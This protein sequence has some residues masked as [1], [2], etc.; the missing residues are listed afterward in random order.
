MYLLDLRLKNESNKFE[1]VVYSDRTASS[2]ILEYCHYSLKS[3]TAYVS[4]IYM[5]WTACQKLRTV[6]QAQFKANKKWPN[7]RPSHCRSI[8]MPILMKT[9]FE[10]SPNDSKLKYRSHISPNLMPVPAMIHFKASSI[11]DPFFGQSRWW[12]S[13]M[14]IPI[15]TQLKP[16]LTMA[17]FEASF[18][19]A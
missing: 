12:P 3:Y 4:I 10:A 19:L 13:W 1:T 9:N 7:L 5:L 8:F 2:H 18:D 6:S 14:P 15:I 16:V 11:H 17:Q